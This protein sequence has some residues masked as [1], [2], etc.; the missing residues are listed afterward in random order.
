MMTANSCG[1]CRVLSRSR[2]SSSGVCESVN[3]LDPLYAQTL[4]KLHNL[5]LKQVKSGHRVNTNLFKRKGP[6]CIHGVGRLMRFFARPFLV[7]KCDTSHMA[8]QTAQEE[9]SWSG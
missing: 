1:C 9:G 8:L 2:K 7:E 6:S 5:E 4:V 3:L